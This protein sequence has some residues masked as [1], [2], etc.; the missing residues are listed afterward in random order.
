MEANSA[1]AAYVP[2]SVASAGSSKK[3]TIIQTE[4]AS[5]MRIQHVRA[6]AGLETGVEQVGAPASAPLRF[7]ARTGI[8]R[9]GNSGSSRLEFVPSLWEFPFSTQ[10]IA[11]SAT[12]AI[13]C[14]TSLPSEDLISPI[15]LPRG[16]PDGHCFMPDARTKEQKSP[17]N[18]SRRCDALEH[19]RDGQALRI[20][21]DH[22]QPNLASFWPAAAPGLRVSISPKSR[23][24]SKRCAK[25]SVCRSE[26]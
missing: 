14:D 24:S 1:P 23:C 21:P 18:H 6:P 16:V 20:E 19:V 11:P 22:V 26:P 17:G 4:P 10:P 12:V 15:W 2:L 5:R 25:L 8:A 13:C 7:R 3:P 9:S